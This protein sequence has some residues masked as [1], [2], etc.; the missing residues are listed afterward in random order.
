M[1]TILFR[2]KR[3]PPF[4]NLTKILHPRTYVQNFVKSIQAVLL[5]LPLSH[6]QKS[7]FL[8]PLSMGI[9]LAPLAHLITSLNL[10][11]ENLICVEI[12]DNNLKELTIIYI[13]I[14]I[15]LLKLI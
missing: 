15:G 7:V 2:L 3:F 13:S 14:Y 5:L 8:L 9:L 10:G 11:S 1:A 6:S 12:C 4:T